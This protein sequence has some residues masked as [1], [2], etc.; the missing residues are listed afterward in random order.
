MR[1]HVD[2]ESGCELRRPQ[3]IQEYERSDHPPA[4]V[5]QHAAHHETSQVTITRR[6]VMSPTNFVGGH[7]DKDRPLRRGARRSAVVDRHADGM[8]HRVPRIVDVAYHAQ[9]QTLGVGLIFLARDVQPRP[10]QQLQRL[11]KPALRSRCALIG[12]WSS[13]FLPSRMAARLISLI[14]LSTSATARSSW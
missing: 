7:Y 1:P 2:P 10:I 14:A 9:P 6:V 8:R 11:V 13:M 4:L 3:V 5:R 12:M